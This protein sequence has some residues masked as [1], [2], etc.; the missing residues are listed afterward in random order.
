VIELPPAV[1]VRYCGIGPHL[2]QEM[3][4][5]FTRPDLAVH[6][7]A[8]FYP[9]GPEVSRHWFYRRRGQARLDRVLL[10]ETRVVH[11]YASVGN[12]KVT[13]VIDPAYVR[14]NAGRQLFSEL[15]LPFA[16]G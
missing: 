15:A 5:Q 13:S 4:A 1:Q 16:G 10:P 12:Q 11:W 9:L 8:V 14:A 7:P 6:P 3:A 2:V